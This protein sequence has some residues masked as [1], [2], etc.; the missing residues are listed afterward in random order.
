MGGIGVLGFQQGHPGL[1]SLSP[2]HGLDAS[3]EAAF[4]DHQLM[5]GRAG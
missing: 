4:F 3:D 5:V 1:R 2:R